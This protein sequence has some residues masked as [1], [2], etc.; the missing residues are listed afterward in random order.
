MHFRLLLSEARLDDGGLW[1]IDQQS[2]PGELF[3]NFV[4]PPFKRLV[5]PLTNDNNPKNFCQ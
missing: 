4:N 3:F 1:K 2:V 5:N